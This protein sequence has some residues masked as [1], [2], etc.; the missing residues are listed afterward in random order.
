[1]AGRYLSGGFELD[2]CIACSPGIVERAGTISRLALGNEEIYVLYRCLA[3]KQ[4]FLD[5]YED[6]F[7][8]VNDEPDQNWIKGPYD[9]AKGKRL[10]QIIMQCPDPLDKFC[11]CDA[12]RRFFEEI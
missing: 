4:Y 12:H 9:A 3:C 5:C 11:D 7:M 8:P 6:H 1:M 2:K 10:E